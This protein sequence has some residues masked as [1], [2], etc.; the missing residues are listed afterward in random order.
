MTLSPA[1]DPEAQSRADQPGGECPFKGLREVA[2]IIDF[3]F[4]DLR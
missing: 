3:G 1:C 2:Q 4:A